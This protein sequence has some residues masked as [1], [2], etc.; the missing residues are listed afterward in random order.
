MLRSPSPPR[1][2]PSGF[3]LVE[4]LVV[5]AIIAVLVGLLL[6]GVQAVRFRGDELK[7][8]GD[9]TGLETALTSFKTKYNRNVPCA[10]GGPMGT[11]RLASAYQD[12]TGTYY[13]GFN[14]ASPEI[15]ALRA[16]FPRIDLRDNGLRRAGVAY[17]PPVAPATT[18]PNLATNGILGSAPA[19]LDPN[20]C[21]V[22]FLT[23]G[24]FTEFSGFA[25]NPLQPFLS[26]AT[27][28]SAQRI[29][30]FF[31]KLTPDR[32]VLPFD[33]LTKAK[34]SLDT[35]ASPPS[36]AM[37]S[38]N[39]RRWEGTAPNNDT[40]SDASNNPSV[41]N[42]PWFVDPWGTP[43]FYTATSGTGT[44]ADYPSQ[45]LIGP[46]GGKFS[47]YNRTAALQLPT[48][49]D[50]T[51]FPAIGLVAF[52]ESANKFYNHNGFQIVS[53]GPNGSD[54]RNNKNWG[55][56]RNPGGL[57]VFGQGDFDPARGGGGDD[58]T[59]FRSKFLAAA[60]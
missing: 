3:T 48:A 5:I 50:Y 24:T 42:E 47:G 6:S 51:G 59:N 30:P 1:R 19:L 56:G 27:N 9:I 43:Y 11:F 8:R 41:S 29:A 32:R 23:G 15:V 57:I 18:S 53:A 31:D 10:G 7:V 14:D 45:C 12:A 13:P 49:A 60:D 21:L 28:P 20:Q 38:S 40:V 58:Y 2:M 46:F 16:I 39:V 33:W 55:F 22:V 44:A 37:S 4:L 17:V 34:G 25:T 26:L 54:I 36:P 35:L 52:R